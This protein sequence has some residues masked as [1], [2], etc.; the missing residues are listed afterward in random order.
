METIGRRPN[1]L[2][3][4]R[5]FAGST[6][7]LSGL[8][9]AALVALGLL[10]P[11]T[12]RAQQAIA[13]DCNFG[14]Q[15]FYNRGDQ[16]CVTGNV[17]GKPPGF[18][19]IC[20]EGYIYVIPAGASNPLADVTPGGAN[21]V[22]S[23]LLGGQFFDQS[24]WLP[25]LTA[26][27][28]ELVVDS[29][30]YGSFGP[31]D[32]RGAGFTVTNDPIVNHVDV[33][34]IKEAAKKGVEAM[35]YAHRLTKALEL[36]DALS[37]ANDYIECFGLAGGVIAGGIYIAGQFGIDI[38]TSYDSGVILIGNKII[39]G[40][41]EPAREMYQGIVN[42]PPD[43]NFMTLVP[44]VMKAQQNLGANLYPQSS[45]P[46][47]TGQVKIGQLIA[48]QDGALQALLPTIEKLQGA[49]NVNDNLGILLQAEQAE[50]FINM[51]M[52]AGDQMLSEIN[53][54][55]NVMQAN[56]TLTKQ[57]DPA[58]TAA[59]FTRVATSGFTQQ[60][61][62][63]LQSYGLSLAQIA[64]VQQQFA[65]IVIPPALDYGTLLSQLSSSYTSVQPALQD[66][67]S[68]VEKMRA[69]NA[70]FAFRPQP[71][72]SLSDATGTTGTPVT[73]TASGT[74]YDASATLTYAWDL[75]GSGTFGDAGGQTISFTPV[76]PGRLPIG[77]KVTD[78]SGNFVYAYASLTVTPTNAAPEITAFTPADVAPL[79]KV[80]AIVAFSVT[81]SDPDNDPITIA[82]TVD[83]NARVRW[84]QS[85]GVDGVISDQPGSLGL[86][87]TPDGNPQPGGGVPGP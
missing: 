24:V 7:R 3:H 56:G 39:D 5:E 64:T 31:E 33:A 68:Q 23:C 86:A 42:D 17:A 76:K 74:S 78:P 20:P 45:N 73:L 59:D 43:P 37:T 41:A 18:N 32:Y 30:P 49:Q 63:K 9:A 85:I 36:I 6:S 82:W 16:V 8:V 46:I 21:F 40:F 61:T 60:E 50:H 67:F 77:V 52:G 84:L 34:A 11:A 48:V 4:L 75:T 10:V 62:A 80:G 53:T 69:E 70:G 87:L 12:A 26:G 83:G 15:D 1:S 27:K 57:A 58:V 35:E 38:A 55:R 54:L 14:F 13:S 51:A 71:T 28:Y 81:A 44:L 29:Y 47:P 79:T 25:P 72:A 65:S 22:S 2:R 66:L 19:H